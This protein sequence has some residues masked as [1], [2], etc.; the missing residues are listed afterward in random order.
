MAT[1]SIPILAYLVFTKVINLSIQAKR[2]RES[3]QRIRMSSKKYKGKK[4][5]PRRKVT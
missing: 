2:G 5:H 4:K 1:K 3:G